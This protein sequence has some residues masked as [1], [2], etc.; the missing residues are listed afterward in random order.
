MDVDV[1]IVGGGPVGGSLACRLA[2][3]GLK[4]AVIDKAALPPMEH[5]EFD[6]RAYAIAAGSRP[7]LDQAGL[8]N[9][10]PLPSCSI[11][12]IRVSDGAL[13]RPASRL[14]LHFDQ[15]DLDGRPLGWMVEARSLRIA[16]NDRLAG[17][18][19]ITVHAPAE[20]ILNRT[21]TAVHVALNGGETF[22][23]R[24]AVAAEGRNSPLRR[25]AGITAATWPYTQSGI[26]C[27]IAHEKPHNNIALEHFLPAGPFAQLPM[28][29]SEAG[30]YIH[31]SA[32]VWSEHKDR[33]SRYMAMDDDAFG[34]ELALRLGNHLGAIRPVGRRWLYPLSAMYV[35][36]MTA[37]RLA[38]AGDAAHGIHPIAGQGLNLGL[39]DA[40][41]LA[42]LIIEARANA[43]D[44][45]S[46]ALLRRYERSRRLDHVSM[47]AATDGLDRLFSTGNPAIRLIRDL[48]LGAVHRLPPLKRAFMRRATG[49]VA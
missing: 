14:F 41:T 20:A 15:I 45:G 42:D 46:P 18:P 9:R 13:G 29:A 12:Q 32:I 34:V 7:L 24:L 49:A 10:L 31:L 6:G 19:N 2:T 48:G 25:A 22:T 43:E 37:T 30:E 36:R 38:I 28:A 39:R 40:I 4:V 47:L 27:A 44:I 17:D 1:C 21:D 16:L 33:A 3:A 35:H 8:W 23:A 5:P 26:V 11:E